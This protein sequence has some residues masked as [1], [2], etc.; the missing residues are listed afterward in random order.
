MPKFFLRIVSLVL[1]PCLLADP[2]SAGP[3]TVTLSSPSQ[4]TA[5]SASFNRQA[6]M[7]PLAGAVMGGTATHPEPFIK[8]FH[9]LMAQKEL[10]AGTLIQSPGDLA[11]GLPAV[12]R[13]GFSSLDALAQ[14]PWWSWGVVLLIMPVVVSL[15]R[16]AL[17]LK[18]IKLKMETIILEEARLA[19]ISSS[20]FD[21]MKQEE[22]HLLVE[23]FLPSLAPKAK[24]KL[25][26]TM[27]ASANRI[28]QLSYSKARGLLIKSTSLAS[29]LV[30]LGLLPITVPLSIYVL[31]VPAG[32]VL[33]ALAILNALLFLYFFALDFERAA[34]A[35][36][37]ILDEPGALTTHRLGMIFN[38]TK[39][40]PEYLR[41][42]IFHEGIHHLKNKQFLSNDALASSAQY[43]RLAET[44]QVQHFSKDFYREWIDKLAAVSDE[45]T[46]IDHLSAGYIAMKQKLDHRSDD[47]W[48]HMQRPLPTD[49][50]SQDGEENYSL[51][52]RLGGAAVALMEIYPADPSDLSGGKAWAFLREMAS[53][54]S[55]EDALNTVLPPD[56][57]ALVPTPKEK[58]PLQDAETVAAIV[59]DVY[60]QIHGSDAVIA[61]TGSTL[62]FEGVHPQGGSYRDLAQDL[63]LVL[64][65]LPASKRFWRSHA[66][67]KPGDAEAFVTE[68]KRRLD[69]QY[70]GRRVAVQ[71]DS[72]PPESLPAQDDSN[73][74]VLHL[75]LPGPEGNPA[76]NPFYT[77]FANP[78]SLLRI[79]SLPVLTMDSLV[80]ESIS[81]FKAQYDQMIQMIERDPEKAIELAIE[82]VSW[83]GSP[84]TQ[85][86][87]IVYYD[88]LKKS[89]LALS[90]KAAFALQLLDSTAHSFSPEKMGDDELKERLE[91]RVINLYSPLVKWAARR[92]AL[93]KYLIGPALIRWLAGALK[94]N[95]PL[96]RETV[97][98]PELER[99]LVI[100]PGILRPDNFFTRLFLNHIQTHTGDFRGKRVL[101]IGTGPGTL[102][103]A[104][105]RAGAQVTA[106]DIWPPAIENARINLIDEASE[107]RDRIDLRV[108]SIE[109]IIALVKSGMV[110]PFD[111]VVYNHQIYDVPKT[112]GRMDPGE[113]HVNY[114]GE[115]FKSIRQ[116]ISGLPHLLKPEGKGLVWALQP[117][118]TAE[119]VK[120]GDVERN[121]WYDF[122]TLSRL[123]KALPKDWAAV[124]A[125]SWTMLPERLH[126]NLLYARGAV[127][128]I[129]GN[130]NTREL[131]S[132]P[133]E[134]RGSAHGGTVFFNAHF[135]KPQPVPAETA[136]PASADVSEED[137][138]SAEN[139]PPSIWP[140]ILS[141]AALGIL[142]SGLIMAFTGNPVLLLFPGAIMLLLGALFLL[143]AGSRYIDK[144]TE[145]ETLG[146]L[147][148]AFGAALSLGG[149]VGLS[150]PASV[151][152]GRLN[153]NFPAIASLAALI[154]PPSGLSRPW[155]KTSRSAIRRAA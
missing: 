78:K 115:E 102:G 114:A 131:A 32:S 41:S 43:L 62:Y 48:T 85:W 138:E 130:L 30:V 14:M 132:P 124:Q 39:R 47:A 103:I 1:I 77:Y 15:R 125:G 52:A 3:W 64:F 59:K 45:I 72:V 22:I 97:W 19:P 90:E 151:E 146:Y 94:Q 128:V 108:N 99:N 57:P 46:P 33:G 104:L 143:S 89:D 42:V 31:A 25:K 73:A 91:R 28:D 116:A 149:F 141:G 152:G 126:F 110:P 88:V 6:L 101:D 53:G 27:A 100:H 54:K 134:G 139:E 35:M 133:W 93:E 5:P 86:T 142:S 40:S 16:T 79:M 118:L 74:W 83:L 68:L 98:V 129:K 7:L 112:G 49:I 107:V 154:V 66:A 24:A 136:V 147:T 18:V 120:F 87:L 76:W 70:G 12:Q 123:P 55:S 109:E 38:P 155:L 2:I 56:A 84:T 119:A 96:Q 92:A 145:L 21:A 122:W 37:S 127:F 50:I 153:S 71:I 26:K 67:S 121:G 36:E 140:A 105:A 20:D 44:L 58:N 111:Y 61:Q 65:K 4:N 17:R 106:I 144:E 29:G 113:F 51:S 23:R 75:Q 8:V 82:L 34:R 135:S 95:K 150:L 80:D 117:E 9:L 81:R 69:A 13:A 63:D 60:H 11:Q 137:E 148:I 10:L